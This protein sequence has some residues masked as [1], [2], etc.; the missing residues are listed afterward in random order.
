[1]SSQGD[2]VIKPFWK[3]LEQKES[4]YLVSLYRKIDQIVILGTPKKI[5]TEIEIVK[6]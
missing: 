3:Y 6:K 4:Q 2:R 1:M 5:H